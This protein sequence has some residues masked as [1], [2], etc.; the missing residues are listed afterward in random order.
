MRTLR[1]IGVGL[2]A[3]GASLSAGATNDTGLVV[4]SDSGQAA[5]VSVAQVEA[6]Q[7]ER[8]E[9]HRYLESVSA[10]R[11]WPEISAGI[12]ELNG[13][14]SKEEPLRGRRR[15]E[16]LYELADY[17]RLKRLLVEAGVPEL[18]ATGDDGKTA[19]PGPTRAEREVA[20]PPRRPAPVSGG[21]TVGF[22]EWALRA[23]GG[24]VGGR[25][26]SPWVAPMLGSPVTPNGYGLGVNTDLYGRPHQ[27]RLRFDGQV[28]DP[29]F[30]GGVK[31]NAY[32]LGVHQDQFGRPVY[33]SAP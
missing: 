6:W 29:I 18:L 32:G 3:A 13:T 33:D 31:R 20:A 17:R 5:T 1:L 11:Y 10:S 27:Y 24:G 12:A 15:A 4:V 9:I 8:E 28:L 30:Q 23:D 22:W 14:I 25:P 26:V 7:K 19:P 16:V 21:E 2:C